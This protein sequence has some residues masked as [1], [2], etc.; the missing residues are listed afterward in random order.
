MKTKSTSITTF[1]LMATLG[2]ICATALVLSSC[3]TN[4]GSVASTS[5]PPS[6]GPA[7]PAPTPGAVPAQPTA[8]SVPPPPSPGPVPYTPPVVSDD[9]AV[10]PTFSKINQQILQTSCVSCHSTSSN[11]ANPHGPAGGLDLSTYAGVMSK[12]IVG[13]PER[14]TLYQYIRGA[15]MP[16]Q[17]QL[18][19]EQILAIQNWIEAGAK[20]N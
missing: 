19:E 18:P 1:L 17:G 20:N 16:P 2:A 5:P 8:G 6:V 10:A 4:N 13:D 3:G 11:G 7:P 12:V 14:S 15:Q 9:P